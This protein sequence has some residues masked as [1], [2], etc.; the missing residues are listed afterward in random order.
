MRAWFALGFVALA[1]CESLHS[2]TAPE[3]APA[4]L[5]VATAPEP[6][7][8]AKRAENQELL[9]VAQRQLRVACQP[10]APFNKGMP[11][12]QSLVDVPQR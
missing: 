10:S 1:G 12:T 3:P 4:P 8:A 9:R 5:R 7:M 2:G 6:P 11:P